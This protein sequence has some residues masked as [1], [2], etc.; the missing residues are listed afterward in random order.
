M[1]LLAHLTVFT[2]G[3]MVVLLILAV[4]LSTV[5]A[6]ALP[7]MSHGFSQIT[8]EF[9]RGPLSLIGDSGMDVAVLAL[10]IPLAAIVG[11]I[12]LAALKI[13]KGE[14]RRSSNSN[15]AEEARMIQDI[16]H[17][18]VKMEQRVESLETL[19]LDKQRKGNES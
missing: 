16:Y 5:L 13:M 8:R 6:I 17:G 15:D 4:L 12:F 1:R 9:T 18:L 11:G 14:S 7:N 2:C 10:C 3:C 19:L